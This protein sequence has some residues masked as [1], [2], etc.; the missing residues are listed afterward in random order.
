VVSAATGRAYTVIA[1]GKV[2]TLRR[3]RVGFDND[4]DGHFDESSSY[5]EHGEYYY[6]SDV[7]ARIA[8]LE[9][10][11]YDCESAFLLGHDAAAVTYMKKYPD[12]YPQ[13]TS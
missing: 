3:V 2:V 9:Q 1:E 11:L 4:G 5:D 8:E 12:P 7:D 6:A 10:R 13:P